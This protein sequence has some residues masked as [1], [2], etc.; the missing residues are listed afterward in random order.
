MGRVG[1][2]MDPDQGKLA[3]RQVGLAILATLK[4]HLGS[5]NKVKRVI[6]VLGMVNAIPL[7]KNILLSLMDA[8]NYLLKSG[9][10]KMALGLEVLSAWALY[11]IIFRWKLKP[12]LNL[13]EQK[14]RR[15]EVWEYGS[16]G[17]WEYG[18]EISNG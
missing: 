11:R 17:V 16:M 5:L 4:N 18:N 9:E 10:K 8:V 7:S 2:D 14:C 6:K 15:L 13:N 12:S 3:A 1:E